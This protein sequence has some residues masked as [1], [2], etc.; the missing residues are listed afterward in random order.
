MLIVIAVPDEYAA[1]IAVDTGA[2]PG[3]TWQ[4]PAGQPYAVREFEAAG[5]VLLP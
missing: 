1:V 3:T 4:T 5:G 2:V